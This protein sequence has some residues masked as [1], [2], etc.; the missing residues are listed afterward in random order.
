MV[1]KCFTNLYKF[2][3][4]FWEFLFHLSDWHWCSNTG[5]NVFTL[6]IL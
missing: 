5:N 6:S 4:C 3:E 1:F 2:F